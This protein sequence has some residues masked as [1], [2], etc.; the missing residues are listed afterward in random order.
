MVHHQLRGLIIE[1]Y[2][3]EVLEGQNCRFVT[4][5]QELSKYCFYFKDQGAD[6]CYVL[7]LWEDNSEECYSGWATATLGK[8]RF[9]KIAKLPENFDYIP[10]HE[11]SLDIEIFK[12]N[13]DDEMDVH[14]DYFEFSSTGGD[15]YY[16]SGYVRIDFEQLSYAGP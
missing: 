2:M 6:E 14:N 1:T 9:K 15:T 11:S 12:S 10:K 8:S 16:P 7:K 4:T 13:E 5:L 3:G